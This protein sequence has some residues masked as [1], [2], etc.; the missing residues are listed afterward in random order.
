MKTKGLTILL[1]V[2]V[3]LTA[4]GVAA[5]APNQVMARHVIASGGQISDGAGLLLYSTIGEAAAGPLVVSG[6]YGA[7]AG[8]LLGVNAEQELYLPAITRAQ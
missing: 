2:A 8:F 1:A 6:S 4:F 5:A 3:L 7:G